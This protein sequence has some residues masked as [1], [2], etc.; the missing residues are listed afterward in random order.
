MNLPLLIPVV[1][2]FALRLIA[3]QVLHQSTQQSFWESF[4]PGELL[5]LLERSSL[6]FPSIPNTVAQRRS[7]VS[8]AAFTLPAKLDTNFSPTPDS[9]TDNTY[10]AEDQLNAPSSN[11]FN[12]DKA[13]EDFVRHYFSDKLGE[14]NDSSGNNKETLDGEGSESEEHRFE[15]E[16]NSSSTETEPLTE[17]TKNRSQRKIKEKCRRV[18]KQKQNCL[19]CENARSG[20]KSES[21][22]FSRASEPQNY[23]FERERSYKKQRDTDE[24]TSH[25]AEQT[26]LEEME[27]AGADKSVEKLNKIVDKGK[28]VPKDSS[29]CIQMLRRGKICY[30]CVDGDGTTTKCYVP[31]ERSSG[32]AA[33]RS[34]PAK[35]KEHK[36]QKT[37]QR[38]Y[39]RT[40]SYSFEK[41]PNGTAASE[42]PSDAG[43]LENTDTASSAPHL[44]EKIFIKVVKQNETIG[45]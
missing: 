2:L 30:Q 19:I 13:Y 15:T 23:S 42:S 10:P 37:Q 29:T 24:P 8:S 43:M 35:G 14:D 28:H 17:E 41:G 16:D 39:K 9:S 18:K 1:S 36:V 26:S 27:A 22:S 11:E 12:Y 45:E 21:C 32:S 20:E 6:S 5:R 34:R 3:T 40:I 33:N 25:S 7:D 44:N 4:A 31:R 38:I